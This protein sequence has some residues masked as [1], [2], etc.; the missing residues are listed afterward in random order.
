MK[1]TKELVKTERP[2]VLKPFDEMEKWMEESWMR[3]FSLFRAPF[4]TERMTEF[5]E[6]S[7]R[8][9]IYEEGKDVVVKAALP[10]VKKGDITIDVSD[11]MLTISGEKKHEDKVEKKD[12]YRYESTYGNFS[13]SFELPGGTDM[14]KA[15]A[16]FEDGVLEIR[17]PKSD[18]AVQKSRTIKIQ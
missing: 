17:V 3:P 18:E 15:K 11:N 12:Y 8:V 10:G 16:H 4:W 13:R 1:G 5:E 14:E 2:R 7:P 6:F 9:D